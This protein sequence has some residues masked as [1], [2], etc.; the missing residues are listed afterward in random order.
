MSYNY[1]NNVLTYNEKQGSVVFGK[2]SEIPNCSGTF[3]DPYC[4]QLTNP[5]I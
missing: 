2:M 1:P 3:F 4:Y 5:P